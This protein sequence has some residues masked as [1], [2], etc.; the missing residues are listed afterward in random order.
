M[1]AA[2]QPA[3]D[4]I[5]ALV[6]GRCARFDLPDAEDVLGDVLVGVMP[7]VQ[8]R[9]PRF[10][11]GGWPATEDER[12]FTDAEIDA[13]TDRDRADGISDWHDQIVAYAVG[14]MR[15]VVADACAER[16]KERE[17]SASF[18]LVADDDEDRLGASYTTEPMDPNALDED[19]LISGIDART[20]TPNAT[21]FDVLR[22]ERARH[23]RNK[24][25]TQRFGKTV[26]S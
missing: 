17:I 13:L 10:L 11:P 12:N 1:I 2:I 26:R 8:P 15:N 6:F 19:A 20:K 7:Q 3:I 4:R 5:R 25:R 18:V 23:A 21:V 22:E 16:K 14:C 9:S 24:K